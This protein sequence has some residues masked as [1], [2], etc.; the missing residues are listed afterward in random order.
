MRLMS[1]Y[2]W[3]RWQPDTKTVVVVAVL[4]DWF[5]EGAGGLPLCGVMLH[6]E[7][8]MLSEGEPLSS[9]YACQSQV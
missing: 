5:N 8:A 4:L 3:P 7:L 9:R 6:T 2:T 1:R